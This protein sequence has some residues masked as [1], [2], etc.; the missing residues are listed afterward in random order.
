MAEPAGAGVL[1]TEAH[2]ALQRVPAR[3]RHDRLGGERFSLRQGLQTEARE[4]LG[5]Q[6]HAGTRRSAEPG[7][8]RFAPN[9][10]DRERLEQPVAD[11]CTEGAAAH[12]LESRGGEPSAEMAVAVHGAGNREAFQRGH[13]RQ[14]LVAIDEAAFGARRREQRVV[15]TVRVLEQVP[16]GHAMQRLEVAAERRR[17]FAIER[18][19]PRSAARRASVAV[20]HSRDSRAASCRCRRVARSWPWRCACRRER[21]GDAARAARPS[22]AP[23]AAAKGPRIGELGDVGVHDAI[24][25]RARAARAMF[26]HISR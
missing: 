14:E 2:T 11:E 13:A 10:V 9:A 8:T 24:N 15:E 25:A 7:S 19:P 16:H 5:R 17:D 21:N 26:L 23:R 6:R 22:F 18:E 4:L 3:Q 1:P 20:N 12:S